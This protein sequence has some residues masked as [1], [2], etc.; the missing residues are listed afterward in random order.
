MKT[1]KQKTI[2]VALLALAFATAFIG[3]HNPVAYAA[4]LATLL[5]NAG[6]DILAIVVDF[7]HILYVGIVQPLIEMIIFP[8]LY[9]GIKNTSYL[10]NDFPGTEYIWGILLGVANGI[11]LLA[12]FIASIAI[13]ARIN[14]TL[15]NT[16]KFLG[17]FIAAVALSNLSLYIV[18][19]IVGISEML[20]GV[21]YNI[22]GQ[23]GIANTPDAIVEFLK[24]MANQFVPF[25]V[26]NPAVL[27]TGIW[28]GGLSIV[29]PWIGPLLGIGMAAN[30]D[31]AEQGRMTTILFIVAIIVAWLILKIALI[32]FERI[33]RLFLSAI[34]APVVFALGLLPNFSKLT[35]QWWE[36]LLL[37]VMIWP[38]VLGIIIFS[39]FMFSIAEVT[40]P[41]AAQNLG[42]ALN[43]ITIGA[44]IASNKGDVMGEDT[45]KFLALLLGLFALW[46]AGMVNKSLKLGSVIAGHV[47]TPQQAMKTGQGIYKQAADNITGKAGPSKF[48]ADTFTGKNVLG[49]GAKDFGLGMWDAAQAGK[50]GTKDFQERVR[51]LEA[52]RQRAGTKG[53]AIDWIAGQAF[54]RA[55]VK[56]YHK[57]L[58]GI[59]TND[60][61]IADAAKDV[62]TYSTQLNDE[63]GKVWANLSPKEKKSYTDSNPKINTLNESLTTAQKAI[64]FYTRQSRE[65]TSVEEMDF[66]ALIATINNK[67]EK[68]TP[69]EILKAVSDVRR[70]LRS[71]GVSR[72]EKDLLEGRLAESGAEEN[73]RKYNV[74]I[75]L[76]KSAE[77]SGYNSEEYAEATQV[78][79]GKISE[80]NTLL[81][82][83]NNVSL[84]IIANAVAQGANLDDLITAL[85][86][87]N[88]GIERGD[89][90]DTAMLNIK[91]DLGGTAGG[92]AIIKTL[93]SLNSQGDISQLSN[94]V[95][96]RT[97]LEDAGAGGGD[98]L[99]RLIGELR[100][101]QA[102]A[103]KYESGPINI[104]VTNEFK[105]YNQ[106]YMASE[107][108]NESGLE[109]KIMDW[110]AQIKANS[111]GDSNV[112]LSDTGMDPDEINKALEAYGTPI[113]SRTKDM[114]INDLNVTAGQLKDVL[115]DALRAIRY[116]KDTSPPP[117]H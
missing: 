53:G 55:G 66:D 43:P 8:M 63:S 107:S 79:Q 52:A 76:R 102:T 104:G 19:A 88:I 44:I 90:V 83:N 69:Q 113:Q 4:G 67:D 64:E 62:D 10:I 116:R 81:G 23:L 16:K 87:I 38:I 112:T 42:E 22:A 71:P 2:L 106:Q 109:S 48:I 58:G 89:S 46:G 91:Q 36:S 47:E 82:G 96:T 75:P 115:G 32:L 15:Y 30:M 110:I 29:A 101:A 60:A 34:T 78:K 6:T 11:Y 117:T 39:L 85:R 7:I 35:S 37:W 72:D 25:F 73:L 74:K 80:I 50:F 18:R 9:F 3:W 13:I 40:T 70:A 5:S 33:I 84:Q 68:S 51:G 57:G 94:R 31:I 111:G 26:G 24:A 93:E 77:A 12:L 28:A 21:L 20:I 100:E 59:K 105:K 103:S 17:G 98:T 1:L 54:N 95:T 27:L 65:K 99:V 41:E 14:T 56:T 92:E 86:K 61:L 114:D 97:N 49:K 45:Q 108:L